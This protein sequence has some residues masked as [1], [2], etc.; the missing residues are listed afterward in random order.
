MSRAPNLKLSTF[1]YAKEYDTLMDEALTSVCVGY[2]P[3]MHYVAIVSRS[4][5]QVS[6]EAANP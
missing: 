3:E 6:N 5:D 1:V 2:I 4:H